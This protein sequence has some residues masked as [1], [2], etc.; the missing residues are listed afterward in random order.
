[1]SKDT[2]Y[3]ELVKDWNVWQGSVPSKVLEYV[4]YNRAGL[5]G[6]S[7]NFKQYL[8]PN[9][10]QGMEFK[11]DINDPNFIPNGNGVWSVNIP[12]Y[13]YQ[14]VDFTYKDLMIINNGEV[15]RRRSI[16]QGG[17]SGTVEYSVDPSVYKGAF[18][19]V[20]VSITEGII[21]QL[22]ENTNEIKLLWLNFENY[23]TKEE[24][25]IMFNDINVNIEDFEI[26]IT[27]LEVDNVINKADITRIDIKDT[28]Q[29]AKIN[30][31]EN[32]NMF[33]DVNYNNVN[34]VLTFT[35]YDDTTKRN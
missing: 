24:I 31:L 7:F 27:E 28:Q 23:Y 33:K 32:A 14:N 18:E 11:G 34:G 25:D 3:Y 13:T 29:D 20:D 2:S 8:M 15:I 10:P 4:A 9:I 30:D 12:Y 22:G 19:Q 6:I 17:S 16:V 21:A 1:M 35:R 26:R 5:I